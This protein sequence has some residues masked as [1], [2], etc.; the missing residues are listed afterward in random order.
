M[1]LIRH[2]LS[3]LGGGIAFLIFYL[4]LGDAPSLSIG[5]G[6][7]AYG[8]VQLIFRALAPG[9]PTGSAA[10]D[11]LTV[12]DGHLDAINHLAGVAPPALAA[13]LRRLED[14]ALPVVYR[15]QEHPEN[16]MDQRRLLTFYLGL[17]RRLGEHGQR[18]YQLRGADHPSLAR[19]GA[20]LD[21]V[22]GA[23]TARA[24]SA[25]AVELARLE[26]ELAVLERSLEAERGA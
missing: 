7:A 5:A 17:G 25:K 16:A 12:A 3:G 14:V 18:L 13:R 4:G 11:I 1:D 9:A 22:T 6:L 19:I 15:V 2:V 26:T 20:M 21:E 8:A 23:F 24:E 10:V